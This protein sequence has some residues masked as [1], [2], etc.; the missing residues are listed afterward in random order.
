MLS[1]EGYKPVY[2]SLSLS[3][4]LGYLEPA[5]TASK[6]PRPP[7]TGRTRARLSPD[8]PGRSRR[9]LVHVAVVL[10]ELVH[11]GVCKVTSE[12]LV[13]QLHL[14]AHGVS[15][16]ITWALTA[17]RISPRDGQSLLPGSIAS[18][19]GPFHHGPALQQFHVVADGVAARTHSPES[20]KGNAS[21][22]PVI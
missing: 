13:R 18:C 10:D 4:R 8:L 2:Q 7:S 9:G 15:L 12:V 1:L 16:A 20:S 11:Q 21:P 17:L 6:R 5:F 3:G 19:R 14:H 22:R